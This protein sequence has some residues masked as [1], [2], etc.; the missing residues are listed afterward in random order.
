MRGGQT[1]RPVSFKTIMKYITLEAIKQ[2][3]NIDDYFT[4]DDEYLDALGDTAEE[5]VEQQVNADLY[6]VLSKNNG[7]LPAPL[8]HAMK[9]IVE[10]LYDNR[11]SNDNEIPKAFY[12]MCGLYR[13]YR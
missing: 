1:A 7:T 13:N 3:L 10:Y 8:K 12:Y 6:D 11:G 2:Q 4:E 9:M 5:L